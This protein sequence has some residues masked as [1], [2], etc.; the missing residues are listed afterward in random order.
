MF[1][2]VGE[3]GEI[4]L[5]GRCLL[6]LRWPTM[7]DEDWA[8]EGLNAMVASVSWRNAAAGQVGEHSTTR[9][10]GD[11]FLDGDAA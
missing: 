10:R 2:V 5:S 6:T 9:R 3:R 11:L 1:A 7:A 8:T 4:T